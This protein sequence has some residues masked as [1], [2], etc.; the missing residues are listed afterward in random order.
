MCSELLEAKE[1]RKRHEA[2]KSHP[3][4]SKIITLVNVLAARS[5]GQNK[6]KEDRAGA[7]KICMEKPLMFRFSVLRCPP[8]YQHMDYY[9]IVLTPDSPQATQPALFRF[10]AYEIGF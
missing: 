10:L 6:T 5:S 8:A 2:P 4:P 7:R 3:A 1:R 9:V